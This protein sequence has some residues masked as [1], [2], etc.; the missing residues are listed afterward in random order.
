MKAASLLHE[1]GGTLTLPKFNYWPSSITPFPAS[2]SK[3]KYLPL[4]PL[5]RKTQALLLASLAF[6]SEHDPQIAKELPLFAACKI[7]PELEPASLPR[8]APRFIIP[9]SLPPAEK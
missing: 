7:G 2:S 6:G 4:A 1:I 9:A 5:L 8:M 3:T